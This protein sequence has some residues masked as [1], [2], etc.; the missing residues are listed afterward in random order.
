MLES[1][2][3]ATSRTKQYGE[4]GDQFEAFG[5]PF[6]ILQVQKVKLREVAEKWYEAEGM[7]SPEAFIAV[8]KK[9]HPVKGYDPEQ[10][11]YLHLFARRNIV[12]ATSSWPGH[13]IEDPIKW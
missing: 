1:R 7:P 3:T 13:I 6:V 8:W 4:R 2:K 12:L 11:V 10:E 9:I 5:A